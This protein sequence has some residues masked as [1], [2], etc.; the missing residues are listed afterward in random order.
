M[1]W[2]IVLITFNPSELILC[3]L[4]CKECVQRLKVEAASNNCRPAKINS[5]QCQ[6]EPSQSSKGLMCIEQLMPRLTHSKLKVLRTWINPTPTWLKDQCTLNPTKIMWISWME[7][8]ILL[9]IHS[10][11]SLIICGI[12]VPSRL[13]NRLTTSK[14]WSNLTFCTSQTEPQPARNQL[15]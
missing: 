2:T 5:C 15:D 14:K 12:I 4:K 7:T 10:T 6:E 9:W 3:K 8:S 13:T 11:I 1:K